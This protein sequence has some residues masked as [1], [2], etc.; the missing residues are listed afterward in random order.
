[1]SEIS[2]NKINKKQYKMSQNETKDHLEITKNMQNIL[3]KS[4]IFACKK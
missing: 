4:M 2:D 1:M 3:E